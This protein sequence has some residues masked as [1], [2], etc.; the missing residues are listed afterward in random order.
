MKSVPPDLHLEVTNLQCKAILKGKY[1]EK[2]LVDFYNCL[3]N[4]TGSQIKLYAH[5]LVSVFGSTCVKQ[6]FQI[7]GM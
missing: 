7:W 5:I 1:Q 6:H 2:N 4:A 3:P